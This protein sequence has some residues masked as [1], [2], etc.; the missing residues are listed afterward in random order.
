MPP[1]LA[2]AITEQATRVGLQVV[3][4]PTSRPALVEAGVAPA[5]AAAVAADYA[6][7]QLEG[8]RVA[9]FAVALFAVLS[10]WFT[11]KLPGGSTARLPEAELAPMGVG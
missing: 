5:D 4:V 2:T 3:P 11:R 8:L 7:A 9:L 6:N 1:E 10:V